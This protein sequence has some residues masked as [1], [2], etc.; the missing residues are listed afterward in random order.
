MIEESE[1][2]NFSPLIIRFIVTEER[3]SFPEI[4]K[5]VEKEVG[6][7]IDQSSLFL[8]ISKLIELKILKLNEDTMGTFSLEDWKP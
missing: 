8:A 1:M 6:S 4:A 5:C 3:A 2:Y 7:R